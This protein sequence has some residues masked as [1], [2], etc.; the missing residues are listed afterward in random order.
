MIAPPHAILRQLKTFVS[1]R[2]PTGAQK[3][4]SRSIT[5]GRPSYARIALKEPK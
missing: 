1:E 4:R 5:N 3:P 2:A